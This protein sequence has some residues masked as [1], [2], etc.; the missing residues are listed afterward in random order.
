MPKQFETL[1]A[2]CEF[3]VVVGMWSK[4]N[5][6][7]VSV[8]DPDPFSFEFEAAGI[9]RFYWWNDEAHRVQTALAPDAT[10][11]DVSRS[12]ALES[13]MLKRQGTA[14]LEEDVGGSG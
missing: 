6:G 13:M 11:K 7:S 8:W 5:G 14:L 9:R 12:R 3:D 1:L 10:M 2:Q 4:F